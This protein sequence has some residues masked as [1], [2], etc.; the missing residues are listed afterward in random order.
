[1]STSQKA[2]VLQ[3]KQ[4]DFTV[5][6]IPIPGPPGKDELLVKVKAVALNPADWLIQRTG[7]L[8][9]KYPAVLGFDI[10]GEVVKVGEDEFASKFKEGDR[11]AFAAIVQSEYSGFQQHALAHADTT[12]IIP[13]NISY[14]EAST[15]PVVLST[16]YVGL[17]AEH[18][19]G[20]GLKPF[21]APGGTGAY[22]GQAILIIGGSSSVGH[23]VIQLAKLSGFS[24]I[25]TTASL[26]HTEYL[27]SFGATHVL[28]RNLPLDAFLAA[29]ME[30]EGLPK[31]EYAYDAIGELESS[32]RYALEAVVPS[33]SSIVVTVNPRLEH[34]TLE[35]KGRRVSGFTSEKNSEG[36]AGLIMD[37]FGALP[38]LLEKGLVKGHRFEVLPRGLAG[39]PDGLARLERKEIS[40]L[41]LVA[42]PDETA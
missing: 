15:L 8:V 33:S 23:S 27:K 26:K 28:N 39:I 19:R 20:L 1:M 34:G 13:Q 24:H 16:A 2:L 32:F 14:D 29:L 9:E 42:H 12:C 30:I 18:P 11:V 25:I 4:G 17:Y 31:L 10:S 21:T 37:L 22:A 35:L 36:N 38:G 41:K 40:G 5:A 3:Q 6:T 7:L